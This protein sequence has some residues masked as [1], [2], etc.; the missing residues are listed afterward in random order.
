MQSS[1]VVFSAVF[2]AVLLGLASA[3]DVLPQQRERRAPSNDLEGF[4]PA[5]WDGTDDVDDF[6]PNEYAKRIADNDFA[7]MRHEQRTNSLRRNRV[8]Q[9]MNEMFAKAGKRSYNDK[10]SLA[11]ND[12]MMVRQDL[13]NGRLYRS[14]L[15]RMLS[16]AGKR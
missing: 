10:R 13:A 1:I 2:A 3:A 7:A 14:L 11:Q 6:R 8:L 15:D 9:A 5:T 16:E 12:Y 4:E